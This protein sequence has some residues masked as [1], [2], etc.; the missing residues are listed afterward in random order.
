[1]EYPVYFYNGRFCPNCG[2]ENT[3]YYENR[4]M[5]KLYR[6]PVYPID[7]FVC[8]NCKRRFFAKWIKTEEGEMIPVPCAKS[9]IEKFENNIA[10]FAQ[11]HE[12]TLDI[13]LEE[14]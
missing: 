13:Y 3:M 9:T 14:S 2:A 11:Q 8:K 6:D 12:R 1:M 4:S 7:F 5:K 10:V